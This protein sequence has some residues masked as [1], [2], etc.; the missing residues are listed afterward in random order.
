[1]KK[2]AGSPTLIQ[3]KEVETKIR[4]KE[5]TAQI[6]QRDNKDQ[7]DYDSKKSNSPRGQK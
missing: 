1:M 4:S 7:K 2:G 3:I 6:K 5:N